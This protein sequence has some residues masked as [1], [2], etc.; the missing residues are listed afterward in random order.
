[1]VVNIDALGI[2]TPVNAMKLEPTDYPTWIGSVDLPKNTTV[3]WKCLK[4]EAQEPTKGL[5]WQGGTNNSFTIP[6]SGTISVS[7]SF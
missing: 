2:W 5:Q 6:S 4:R 3:E 1:M 7:A